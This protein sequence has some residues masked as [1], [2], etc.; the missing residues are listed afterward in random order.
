MKDAKY[1]GMSLRNEYES[2][3]CGCQQKKGE[4]NITSIEVGVLDTSREGSQMRAI[5]PKDEVIPSSSIGR[6]IEEGLNQEG[7]LVDSGR[8]IK[9]QPS[10]S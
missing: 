2:I 3:S 4:L 8:R 1:D 7:I 6:T 5:E 10:A 9:R